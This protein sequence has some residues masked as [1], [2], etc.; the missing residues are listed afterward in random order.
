MR[1][2]IIFQGLTLFVGERLTKGETKGG[3]GMGTLTAYLIS[4]PKHASMPAHSHN[5]YWGLI[6][7]DQGKPTGPGRAE[8]KNPVPP[9]TTIQLMG[10]G[11]PTGVTAL[12]SYLDYVPCLSELHWGKSI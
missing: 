11:N 7:R 6:G 4:D 1:A 9:V 8:T 2:R 5:A 12:E 10:Y 3:F